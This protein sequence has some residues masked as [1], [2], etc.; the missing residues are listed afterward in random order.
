MGIVEWVKKNKFKALVVV[1]VAYVLLQLYRTFFGVNALYLDGGG[2]AAGGNF[3]AI[4][5]PSIPSYSLPFQQN[6]TP[7]PDVKDR[8][9]VQES[10]LSLLVKDVTDVR[11]K[12]VKY[13]QDSGGY[14]VSSNVSNPQDAPTATVVVRVPS[15]KLE[16]A[17]NFFHSLSVKVVSENLVGTDV[18]DQYVDIETRIATLEQTKARFETILESATEI[19]DITNLT[20]QILSYQGQID[21]LKG[22]QM[23]LAKNA[24]LAK[25]TIYLSTDEIALPYQPSETF[26]PGVIFKLAVRSLVGFLRNLAE[27]AIWV[28]V[29]AVVWVPAL[30]IYILVRRWLSKRKLRTD[31]TVSSI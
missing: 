5:N 29:Y 23:A 2:S 8:L 10:N 18:T 12:I 22:Q 25:L 21:T 4:S 17:L 13:A 20:Q 15:V 24:E 26:R 31:K 14:M 16:E 6:Y 28:G 1:V 19:A 7:Q 9:V 27:L 3:G 11:N 30:A